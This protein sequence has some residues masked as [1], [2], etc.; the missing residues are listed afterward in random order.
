MLKNK[1]YTNVKQ[2]L[3]PGNKRGALTGKNMMFYRVK[4]CLS[5]HL[6]IMI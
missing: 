6:E 4:L 1:E 5:W 2:P 3:L